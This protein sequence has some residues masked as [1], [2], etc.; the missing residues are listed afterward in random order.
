ML[1]SHSD[2]SIDAISVLIE[3][4]LVSAKCTLFFCHFS[5]QFNRNPG[6]YVDSVLSGRAVLWNVSGRFKA[7]LTSDLESGYL[8]P[9]VVLAK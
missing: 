2:W 8:A 4:H 7:A 9:C 1:T 3:P 5:Q 6:K